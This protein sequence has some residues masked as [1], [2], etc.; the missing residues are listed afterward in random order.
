[1]KKAQTT[2]PMT[3]TKSAP[4]VGFSRCMSPKP[5]DEKMI[6]LRPEYLLRKMVRTMPLNP[7][8]SKMDGIEMNRLGESGGRSFWK[9]KTW[10]IKLTLMGN[11]SKSRYTN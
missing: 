10:R 11:P 1:M 5:S 2:C 8:S 7:T 9:L 4:F 3:H 6:D